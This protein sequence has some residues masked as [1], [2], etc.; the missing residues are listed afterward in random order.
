MR[1]LLGPHRA[2][3]WASETRA[4]AQLLYHTLTTGSGQQT[5]GEEYCDVLQVAGPPG[6]ASLPGPARRGLLV[7]V[8]ALGPYLA[9]RL[10][11]PPDDEFT[12]WQQA[13][14][15]ARAA[16][17]CQQQQQHG[18]QHAPSQ[19]AL[20]MQRLAA[21]SSR[22]WAAA[23]RAA[24]PATRHVP[25]AA[26]WLRQHGG[27]LLRI[28]LALFYVYGLYYQPSKRVAGAML[29]GGALHGSSLD[30]NCFRCPSHQCCA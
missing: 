7:L 4:L 1:R 25:A 9:E 24:E 30:A 15:A 23:T 12:A 28:H 19:A 5:P 10:A 17:A 20:L 2:L 21:S 16:A 14:A 3:R 26:A 27:T 13:Q 6:S 8:Q 18:G 11:A 22:F 29:L